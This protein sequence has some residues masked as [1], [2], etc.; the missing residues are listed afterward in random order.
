MLDCGVGHSLGTAGLI[1]RLTGF[2]QRA[3]ESHTRSGGRSRGGR[4]VAPAWVS[5]GYWQHPVQYA[6]LRT[7]SLEKGVFNTLIPRTV[8]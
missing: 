6:A 7:A 5:F 8:T 1:V 4:Y 3:G 2:S